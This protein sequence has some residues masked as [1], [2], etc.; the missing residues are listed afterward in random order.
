MGAYY[1]YA[2]WWIVTHQMLPREVETQEQRR[3]RYL[4]MATRARESTLAAVDPKMGA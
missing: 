1:C 4:S 2:S 3:R